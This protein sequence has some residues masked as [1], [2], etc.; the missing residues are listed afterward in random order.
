MTQRPALPPNLGRIGQLVEVPLKV[1][2]LHCTNTHWRQRW[3]G[4]TRVCGRGPR[5]KRREIAHLPGEV[6]PPGT[7]YIHEDDFAFLSN[8][9]SMYI[10]ISFLT[11]VITEI[12]KISG[13]EKQRRP[14]E[15]K[16]FGGYANADEKRQ[17]YLYISTGY[18]VEAFDPVAR[19]K[20][21]V[22]KMLSLL[23]HD[24]SFYHPDRRIFYRKPNRIISELQSLGHGWASRTIFD[25]ALKSLHGVSLH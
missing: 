23:E 14:I 24:G 17:K 19:F 13:T 6:T 20:S 8:G 25:E 10:P 16:I 12:N 9:E 3:C 7:A 4:F 21:H 15:R 5:A 1:M 18:E 2:G 11:E 22:S